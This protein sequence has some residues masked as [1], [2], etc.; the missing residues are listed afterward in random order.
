MDLLRDNVCAVYRKYFL[1]AFGSALISCIY[2]VVDMAMVGQYQGPDGTAV[3]AVVRGVLRFLDGAEPRLA[4]PLY[5]HL[6]AADGGDPRHGAGHHPDVCR[7]VPAT[8]TEYLFNVLFSGYPQ[9]GRCVF[10]LRRAGA[11]HQRRTDFAAAGGARAGRD[12]VGHAGHGAAGRVL[13]RV[14]HAARDAGAAVVLKPGLSAYTPFIG[15]D[16]HE[17]LESLFVRGGIPAADGGEDDRP[18]GGR[19]CARGAA[20]GHQRRR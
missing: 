5:P 2:G 17:A 1:A 9:A 18:G 19:R 6:H 8:A 14:G 20:A 16:V 3:L 4:E 10:C 12:L 11:R 13:C 15:G 7:V